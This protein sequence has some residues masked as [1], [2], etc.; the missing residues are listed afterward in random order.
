MK[1]TTW[2]DL[3]WYIKLGLVGGYL[4]LFA[5]IVGFIIGMVEGYYLL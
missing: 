2:S 3:K 5:W 1:Q 4:T